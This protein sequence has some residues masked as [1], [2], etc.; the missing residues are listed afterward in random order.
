MTDAPAIHTMRTTNRIV[1]SDVVD[2]LHL[3]VMSSTNVMGIGMNRGGVHFFFSAL[4]RAQRVLAAARI[5]AMPAPEMWRVGPEPPGD[6]LRFNLS[7]SR[8]LRSRSA[9]ACSG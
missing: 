1:L 6:T 9:P 7:P 8:F 4:T 3:V 5:L 2:F